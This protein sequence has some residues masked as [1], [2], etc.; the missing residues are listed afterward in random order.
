MAN[1]V[2]GGSEDGEEEDENAHPSLFKIIQ[3][4]DKAQKEKENIVTPGGDSSVADVKKQYMFRSG[5]ID[6][7]LQKK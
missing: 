7:K 5:I 3:D 2:F 4:F 1:D 6:D